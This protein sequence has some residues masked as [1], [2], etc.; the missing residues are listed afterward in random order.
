M[1]VKTESTLNSKNTRRGMNPNSRR[2]LEKGRLIRDK[3]AAKKSL[4]ITACV[5]EKLLE[6]CPYDPTKTWREYLAYQWLEQAVSSPSFFKELMERLEGRTVQPVSMPEGLEVRQKIEVI[7]AA[8]I[9]PALS[10]LISCGAVMI[11]QN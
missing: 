8:D 10:A 6:L 4:S 5:R 11:S 9:Q 1:S 3:H 2:N 7:S